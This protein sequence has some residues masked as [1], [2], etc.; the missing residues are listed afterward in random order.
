MGRIT[1]IVLLLSPALAGCAGAFQT[2]G[3]PI[4]LGASTGANAV[5]V[6]AEGPEDMV[7]I[8]EVLRVELA[9][10]LAERGRMVVAAP[11]PGVLAVRAKV[12]SWDYEE[13]GEPLHA[14]R[15]SIQPVHVHHRYCTAVLGVSIEVADPATGKVLAE[16]KYLGVEQ[17]TQDT[18][19]DRFLAPQGFMRK[20]GLGKA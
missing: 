15:A 19:Y 11:G 6:A 14:P 17:D 5:S 1:R 16:R 13:R 18:P 3:G 9:R 12:E 10:E 8:G 20:A 7:E 2:R 4:D